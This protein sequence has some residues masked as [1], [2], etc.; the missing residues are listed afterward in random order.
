MDNEERLK[1][2]LEY[3]KRITEFQTEEEFKKFCKNSFCYY[4]YGFGYRIVQRIETEEQFIDFCM[5]CGIVGTCNM[6]I[7]W[8][9]NEGNQEY[10]EW[11]DLEEDDE[12]DTIKVNGYEI[13]FNPY[14]DNQIQVYDMGEI[15]I[16]DKNC[17]SVTEEVKNKLPAL[18]MY[19]SQ[20]TFDRCGTIKGD[21]LDIFSLKDLE[22][23]V[24]T[25][26]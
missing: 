6:F 23:P 26:I 8:L 11:K 1:E 2:Y 3:K 19:V 10:L 17:L 20:D 14:D 13:G 5:K 24:M 4:P 18:V 22:S 16:V 25:F 21:S 12:F 15:E 9:V 7:P